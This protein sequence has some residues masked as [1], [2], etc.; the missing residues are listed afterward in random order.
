MK[1]RFLTLLLAATA[2][3]ACR[4]EVTLNEKH[5]HETD[6]TPY[7][8]ISLTWPVFS[9][10]DMRTEESCARFNDE[11]NGLVMGIQAGFKEQTKET[12]ASLDSAGMK[13]SAPYELIIQDSVFL[14]DRSYISVRLLS[15]EL[16]GGAHGITNF[17]SVNY[18]VRNQ[19][20]LETK[21]ILDMNKAAEI[22]AL[23]KARLQDP[24]QCF[25]MEA[26][27]V[28]N[29]SALNITRHSL[30]FTYAQ[31]ILGPYSCGTATISIPRKDLKDVLLIRLP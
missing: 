15:Y 16:T 29:L 20:F 18:D 2:L 3:S 14:A 6:Q 17:F 11:L 27:T 23:L 28:E 8:N 31:Y 21:D 22:N 5:I 9:A 7:W 30:E 26:P 1:T 12:V 19:K 25:T 4:K 13:Q 10:D 24:G